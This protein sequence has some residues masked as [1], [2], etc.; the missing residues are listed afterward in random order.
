MEPAPAPRYHEGDEA[1][2]V[3]GRAETR[4]ID[5]RS[6]PFA[7]LGLAL[8]GALDVGLDAPPEP[9]GFHIARMDGVDLHVVG[10]A[11]IGKRLGEG[12]ASRVHRAAD[13]EGRDRNA[14]PGA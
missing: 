11:K 7:H 9:L 14:P 4:D 2:D 13:G 6:V 12:R 8:A 3:P 5:V 1:G 10:L